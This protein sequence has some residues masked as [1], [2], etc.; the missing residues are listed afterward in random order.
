M[1]TIMTIMNR[2]TA[3][4]KFSFKLVVGHS[5]TEAVTRGAL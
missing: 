3:K 2:I 1:M 4:V 5:N